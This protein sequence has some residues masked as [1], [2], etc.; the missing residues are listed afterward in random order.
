MSSLRAFDQKN[1]YL[2]SNAKGKLVYV[3]RIRDPREQSG[4]WYNHTFHDLE[5][6][7]RVRDEEEAK[8]VLDKQ[9]QGSPLGISF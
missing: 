6:A 8:L 5:L 2:R 9:R 4:L 3:V 7:K 1:I